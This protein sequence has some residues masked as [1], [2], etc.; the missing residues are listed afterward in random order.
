MQSDLDKSGVVAQ[1][2]RELPPEAAQPYGFGEFQRRARE[3]ARAGRT[4]AGGQAVAA[5]AV[6]A[7]GVLAVSL[8]LSAPAPRQPASPVAPAAGGTSEPGARAARADFAD[9]WLASLP[10]EPAV[11]SIGTRAAVTGLE[12]RIAQVDDLLSAARLGEQPGELALLQQERTRLIGTLV[13]VRYAETLAN[14]SRY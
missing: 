4:L 12:D 2:L 13:Q 9:R 3:R 8:R 7:V 11:E 1:L 10:P 6:V 5:V 14:E